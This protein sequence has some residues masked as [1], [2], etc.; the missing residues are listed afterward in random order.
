MYCT[1]K[2]Q[3]TK[4][5]GFCWCVSV[6]VCECMCVC[7]CEPTWCAVVM[8]VELRAHSQKEVCNLCNGEEMC[9]VREPSH[10]I[11]LFEIEL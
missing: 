3:K 6:C 2:K 10:Q 1:G 4:Q 9:V 5:E 7:L 11:V 8:H